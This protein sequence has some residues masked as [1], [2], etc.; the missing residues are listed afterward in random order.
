MTAQYDASTP[1]VVLRCLAM[2]PFYPSVRAMFYVRMSQ[3]A[4]QH[5]HRLL[6]HWLKARAISVAGV[7]IHPASRIGPGFAFVHSVGI[8]IGE[9]V[10]AGRN[11]YMHQGVTIGGL[12]NGQ[13][14]LGDDVGIGAGAKVLGNIRIGDRARIG[15][16]AVV[17][18]DVEPDTTV[19][20]TWK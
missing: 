13:P 16:N 15:A 12:G 9:Q 5:G 6:A 2:C 14:R 19:V 8:V 7:E 3:H 4:W 1:R 17:L 18:A 11:L 10:T 20:G